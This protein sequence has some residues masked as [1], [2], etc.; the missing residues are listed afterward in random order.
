MKNLD[1]L[2]FKEP[3]FNIP[4]DIINCPIIMHHIITHVETELVIRAGFIGMRQDEKTYEM[5]PEF[6]WYVSTVNNNAERI[7]FRDY[8]HEYEQYLD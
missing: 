7:K 6:G 2:G 5:K 4:K 1:E 3:F 8:N